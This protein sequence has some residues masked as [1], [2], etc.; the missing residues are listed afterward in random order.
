ML[1]LLLLCDYINEVGKKLCFRR[2]LKPKFQPHHWDS[3]YE[4]KGTA[5]NKRNCML[6]MAIFMQ[7]TSAVGDQLNCLLFVTTSGHAA[8]IFL[9]KF[10]I[11]FNKKR[12]GQDSA[13][14]PHW[15]LCLQANYNIATFHVTRTKMYIKLLAEEHT[16]D[17]DCQVIVLQKWVS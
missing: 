9:V 11:S 13:G 8:C 16:R 7:S 6:G 14:S 3:S 17:Q 1:T 10:S 5:P 4:Q 15:R 2:L 12:T